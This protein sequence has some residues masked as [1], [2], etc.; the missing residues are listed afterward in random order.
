MPHHPR[1]SPNTSET[2]SSAMPA[3]TAPRC[4]RCRTRRR[5][6]GGWLLPEGLRT[7]LG[8]AAVIRLRGAIFDEAPQA[9]R[10]DYS[11]P[12]D[13]AGLKLSLSDQAV[14]TGFAEGRNAARIGNGVGQR[15]ARCRFGRQGH[16]RSLL[17]GHEH[18][19]RCLTC[20]PETLG[21][22]RKPQSRGGYHGGTAANDQPEGTELCACSE[23]AAD[24]PSATVGHQLPVH[25]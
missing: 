12:S 13:L 21:N 20:Q 10:R 24:S 15:L 18:H 4:I 1:G 14:D 9:C 17:N 3:R 8:A 16:L 7:G 25:I 5:C 19:E 6:K 23:G 22:P 2:S 11:P